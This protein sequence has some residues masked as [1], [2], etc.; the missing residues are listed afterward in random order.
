MMF[1]F[2]FFS[3]F[4]GG[5]AYFANAGFRR[6]ELRLHSWG[7]VLEKLEPIDLD[8]IRAIADGFLNADST[9]VDID[10][11]EMWKIIGG[12][13]GLKRLKTSAWAMFDVAVYTERWSGDQGAVVSD[14]IRREALRLN[15]AIFRV[16]MGFFIQFGLLGSPFYLRKAAASYY[17]IYTRLVALHRIPPAGLI[18]GPAI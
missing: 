14:M 8:G 7:E 13:E 12:L 3:I 15:R 17:L 5:I 16:Q 9:Q 10:P 2:L 6:R 4:I 1:F 11:N 18:L